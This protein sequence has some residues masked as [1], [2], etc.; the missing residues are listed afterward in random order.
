[1]SRASCPPSTSMFMSNG[2]LD[3]EPI[4][5]ISQKCQ[6]FCFW[7]PNL[8]VIPNTVPLLLHPTFTH[9]KALWALPPQTP[10]ASYHLHGCHLLRAPVSTPALPPAGSGL[11]ARLSSPCSRASSE[12]LGGALQNA[13]NLT[14]LLCPKPLHPVPLLSGKFFPVHQGPLLSVLTA[15]V[16]ISPAPSPLSLCSSDT[17]PHCGQT[18][19]GPC[20]QAL[21]PASAWVSVS[22]QRQQRQT[23]PDRSSPSGTPTPPTT[24]HTSYFFFLISV[25]PTHLLHSPSVCHSLLRPAVP[26]PPLPPQTQGRAVSLGLPPCALCSNSAR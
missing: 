7:T 26:L 5:L 9:G 23:S 21:E 16:T 12:K 19:P 22:T 8:G 17:G 18:L 3:L 20:S 2:H 13:N 10:T 11:S 6:S 1:M 25:L 24:C 14:G 4:L 15:A